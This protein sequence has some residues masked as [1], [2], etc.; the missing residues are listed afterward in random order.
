M[1]SFLLNRQLGSI[2]HQQIAAAQNNRL[3]KSL[4]AAQNVEFVLSASG[5][6]DGAE[7]ASNRSLAHP[8]GV[9]SITIDPFEGRYLLSAGADSSI[10]I[11]DLENPTEAHA[12]G[13]TTYTPLGHVP[14]TS[15]TSSSLGITHVSFYPFDSLAFLTSGYDH[16][17]KLL[18]SE[19]LQVSAT[20][21][22]DS[23]VYSHACSKDLLVA[24]A[25]QHPAVRLIDLRSGNATHAL[26]GHSGAVL[27]VAWHPKD[28][29]VLASG[30]ADGTIRLWDV[31]KS[32][33]SLG[34]LDMDDHIGLPGHDGKGT[35]ARRRERGV[36]HKGAVNGLTWTS[37][38]RYLVSVGHDERMRVWDMLTGANTLI[39]FGPGLRNSTTTAL[40][41]LV[42][43]REVCG[44]GQDV[45]FYPNPTEIRGFDLLSGKQL[46][47]LRAGNAA[48]ERGKGIVRSRTTS[49]AWRAG[50]DV[51]LYS[52]HADGI[53][54]VWRPWTK[55]DADV[56]REEEEDEAIAG[57]V[58]GE[59]E[60]EK[61][62]KREQLDEIVRDLSGKRITYS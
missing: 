23:T 45:V 54:R 1:N 62:R 25:T 11:W 15:T 28:S 20:F 3:L 41:P 10:A 4:Q 55:E 21:T 47:R 57:S 35:G 48:V 2:N 26:A 9:S 34:A 16:T 56:E 32:A 6:D 19:T 5:H 39:N 38:A 7:A 17:L 12:S 14:T 61:K 50:G 49:L 31:R 43:P 30:A 46:L 18:S 13:R 29:H 60:E 33:S 42:A 40:F 27:A 51:E 37:D 53:I 8:S 24:C 52:A 36:A 59:R 44:P 58:K 22:L